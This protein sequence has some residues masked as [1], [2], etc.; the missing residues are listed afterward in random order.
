MT[1]FTGNCPSPTGGRMSYRGQFERAGSV[2]KWQAELVDP[3]AKCSRAAGV[4]RFHETASMVEVMEAVQADLSA[5]VAGTAR[6]A[7]ATASGRRS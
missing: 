1:A 6:N 2:V 3:V 4:I 7:T 5:N